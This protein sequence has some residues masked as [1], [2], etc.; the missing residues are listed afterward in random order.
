MALKNYLAKIKSSGIY[1]FVFDKSEIPGTQVQTLRLVVGYSD[2]GPY[3]T[4]VYVE[5][6]TQFETIFGGIS[7]KL[8]RKGCFFHRNALQCLETTPI[9]CLNLKNLS[10]ANTVTAVTFDNNTPLAIDDQ[11]ANKKSVVD[12]FNTDRFW[13]LEP[14]KLDSL[15]TTNKYITISATDDKSTSKT[16]YFRGYTPNGYDVTFK[17]YFAQTLNGTDIPSYLEGHEN[18]IM[19][20]YFGEIYVFNG[21]FTDVFK[22]SQAMIKYFET[23]GSEIVLKPYVLDAF[24]N[25]VD[26]LDALAD[27]PNSG[28]INKYEGIMLPDFESPT[29]S[30]LSIDDVFN[31]DYTTHKLMMHLNADM[32]YDVPDTINLAS[33]TGWLNCVNSDGNLVTDGLNLFSA[34]GVDAKNSLYQYDSSDGLQKYVETEWVDVTTVTNNDTFTSFS[35]GSSISY[36]PYDDPNMTVCASTYAKSSSDT[37]TIVETQSI[38]CTAAPTNF[39]L[40][41]VIPTLNNLYGIKTGDRFLFFYTDSDENTHNYIATLSEINVKSIDLGTTTSAVIEYKFDKEIPAIANFVSISDPSTS[42]CLVKCNHKIAETGVSYKDTYLEGFTYEC[43][44]F[45]TGYSKDSNINEI[46]KTLNTYS[47]LRVA[48]TNNVDSEYHYLVDT[49]GSYGEPKVKDTLA[50]VAKEKDNCLAILNWPSMKS[51][52]ANG[53]TIQDVTSNDDYKCNRAYASWVAYYTPVILRNTATGSK[54]EVPSAAMVSNT[55]MAKYESRYPYSI[56]AGPNYGVVYDSALVG[57]EYNYSRADLDLYE[58]YGINCLVYKPYV[59]TYINCQ[60]T[61]KQKPVTTLSK[62]NVRELVIYLQDE[63]ERILTAS[64]WEFNTQSL[65][66]LVKS[67]VD[68]LCEQV[69]VNG[70]LYKFYNQC[71]EFNNTDDVINNEMFVISTSIEPGMGAGKMVQELTIYRKG[72]MSS[73]IQ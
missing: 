52:K 72:G 16:I 28:F 64:Q 29:S 56:V 43:P 59:G 37:N 23:N 44:L 12:L 55:Y 7:K 35:I 66:D 50:Q 17:D 24:G 40:E 5:S 61:A 11:G 3:N 39:K 32:L 70:G 67:K 13:T 57:P 53:K 30:A 45:R 69:R 48:L 1:R 9:F 68:V 10:D 14:E 19:E 6:P 21:Q 22:Q 73:V 41:D 58:P 27:D 38:T 25:P 4:L 31:A 34:Q 63:I 51:F 26:T 65:R 46:L 36:N 33:A 18:D 15:F 42:S 54:F 60:Q 49:F 2:K 8:E 20:D 62:I 71:D 47:G